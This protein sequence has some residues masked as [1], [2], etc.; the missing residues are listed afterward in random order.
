MHAKG[1]ERSASRNGIND[2]VQSVFLK[3]FP[4]TIAKRGVEGARQENVYRKIRNRQ[5]G[6]GKSSESS[7]GSGT[8]KPSIFTLNTVCLR[9]RKESKHNG[10][11][12]SDREGSIRRRGR[13]GRKERSKTDER[14][15]IDPIGKEETFITTL[16]GLCVYSATVAL[17]YRRFFSSETRQHQRQTLGTPPPRL[18]A[19]R[20]SMSSATRNSWHV[21]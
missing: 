10:R 8:I 11:E 17:A 18:V 5:G 12:K 14:R 20:R 16:T 7:R 9:E 13:A 6:K 4:E 19:A 3:D 21:G 1:K 2:H 15:K